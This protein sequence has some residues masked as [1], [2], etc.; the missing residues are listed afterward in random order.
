MVT[1]KRQITHYIGNKNSTKNKS[2]NLINASTINDIN[3]YIYNNSLQC[4]INNDNLTVDSCMDFS[5]KDEF[6][7]H[8]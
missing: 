8:I 7:T 4:P 1:L 6:M 3:F 2:Y 5:T